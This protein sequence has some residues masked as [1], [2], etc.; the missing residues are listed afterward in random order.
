MDFELFLRCLYSERERFRRHYGFQ[1]SDR[2][3]ENRCMG[4]AKSHK[5]KGKD[6]KGGVAKCSSPL[7]KF[8]LRLTGVK[9]RY[10]GVV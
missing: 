4:F 10:H 7:N 1:T 2:E 8:K 9:V 6:F 3:V 5:K